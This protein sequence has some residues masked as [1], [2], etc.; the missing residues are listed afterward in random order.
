[1]ATTKSGAHKGMERY[2]SPVP[3]RW[4]TEATVGD[5]FQGDIH[6]STTE[7]NVQDIRVAC[8]ADVQPRV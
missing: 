2:T 3:C 4:H 1:M 6:S 8:I 5:I 7:A